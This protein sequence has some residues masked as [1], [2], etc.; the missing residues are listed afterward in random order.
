MTC[1]YSLVRAAKRIQTPEHRELGWWNKDQ[2]YVELS[3]EAEEIVTCG[4]W[5]NVTGV[6]T[7]RELV[8]GSH[9]PPL[10]STRCAFPK[11]RPR[12]VAT[13]DAGE[14]ENA[15]LRVPALATVRLTTVH[16]QRVAYTSTTLV[17]ITGKL[18]CV[19][20]ADSVI[21]GIL[22]KIEHTNHL[23]GLSHALVV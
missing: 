11:T 13:A 8:V 19:S 22:L 3:C 1:Y 7:C 14:R 9:G 10:P 20:S 4:L 17:L 5:N 15:L 12:R 23:C 16:A 18:R 6:L 2:D 21:Q